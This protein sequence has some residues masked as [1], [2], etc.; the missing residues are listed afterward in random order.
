MNIHVRTV[1]QTTN[2]L[3]EFSDGVTGTRP[4][5]WIITKTCSD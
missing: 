4:V 5:L 1:C 2:V 3:V